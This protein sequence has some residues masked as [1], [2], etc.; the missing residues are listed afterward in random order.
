MTSHLR[1]AFIVLALCVVGQVA[2]AGVHRVVVLDFDGPRA[3]CESSRDAVVSIL[4]DHYELVARRV[5]EAA[6]KR[7]SG[8]GPDRWRQA[9]KATKVDSVVEGYVAE[10]G[11]HHALTVI[12]RDATTGSEVDQ[13]T[14]KFDTA[15]TAA[16]RAKLESGLLDTLEWVG[17]TTT[18]DTPRDRIAPVP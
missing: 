1:R 12:V 4:G 6:F 18:S 2:E 11:R 10:E 7:G 5:W 15:L 17:V 3:L 9:S 14:V 8:H 16:A 13:V